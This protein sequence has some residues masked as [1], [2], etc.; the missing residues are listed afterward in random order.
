M[1]ALLRSMPILPGPELYDLIY[2]LKRSRNSIDEKIEKASQSLHETSELIE[3]IEQSLNERVEK[4]NSLREEV[5]RYSQLAE[6]EEDKAQAIVKQLEL[7]LNK[8]RNRERWVSLII[9]LIAGI[10]IFALGIF[11]GPTINKKLG[12]AEETAPVQVQV[13]LEK[14]QP[15]TGG[16]QT[17]P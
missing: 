17:R 1:R 6:V 13:P 4:L 3:E 5:E 14:Q 15:K 10:I 12:I 11:F 9:N 8:G 7:T 16:T 2:D